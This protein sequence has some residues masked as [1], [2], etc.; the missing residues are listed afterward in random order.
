M[1]IITGGAGFIGSAMIWQLNQMGIDDI[2]VVD[3]LAKTDKWKNLVNLRYEDY[4]H[5]DQFLKL[6]MEGDDPFDTKAV[7]HMGQPHPLLS[8]IVIFLW[9]TTIVILRWFAV[10]V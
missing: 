3:N 4:L 8:L 6:I 2:L 7:I 1:Y 10:S 5:R 9:K